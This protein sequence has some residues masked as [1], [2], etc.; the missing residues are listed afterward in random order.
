M[1]TGDLRNYVT[2]QVATRTSDGQGGWTTTWADTYY[3]WMRATPLSQSK[4]LEMGGVKYR[5]AV[6]FLGRVNNL[7]SLTGEHRIKWESE[8]YTIYSVVP[9]ETNEYLTVLGYV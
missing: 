5:K 6:E 4:V 8:T 1:K 3:E 7:Y 2:V 9:D